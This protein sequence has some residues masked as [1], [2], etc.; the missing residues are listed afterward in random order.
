MSKSKQTKAKTIAIEKRNNHE[1]V[2]KWLSG[3]KLHKIFVFKTDKAGKRKEIYQRRVEKLAEAKAL[4]ESY[5]KI[6]LYGA[7][8]ENVMPK[9]AKKAVVKKVTAKKAVKKSVTIP[10]NTLKVG[11]K[12]KITAVAKAVSTSPDAVAFTQ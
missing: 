9:K 12:I 2:L 1:V 11:D 6:Y 8:P 7:K 10:K 5:K 4:F 3:Q